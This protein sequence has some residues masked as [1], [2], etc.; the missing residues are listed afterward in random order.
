M[1]QRTSN[2]CSYG[3]PC[4]YLWCNTSQYCVLEGLLLCKSLKLTSTQCNLRDRQSG[5]G[6]EPLISLSWKS[7]DPLA[8]TKSLE[9][10]DLPT[11]TEYNALGGLE[12]LYQVVTNIDQDTG[13]GGSNIQLSKKLMTFVRTSI[14][15]KKL[16]LFS[17]SRDLHM[18]DDKFKSGYC[19]K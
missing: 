19:P 12:F 16:S 13:L 4:L 14:P 18:I 9:G 11:T 15:G 3:L 17:N 7:K 10:F 5:V 1:C 6:I 2:A 8:I